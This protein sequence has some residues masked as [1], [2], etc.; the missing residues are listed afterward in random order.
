MHLIKR[1][2]GKEV[3]VWACP[4]VIDKASGRKFGKSEGN[5]IWLDPAR[6]SV[7]DYYQFWINA[8]DESVESLLKI[9]TEIPLDEVAEIMKLH[10]RNPDQRGAQKALALAATEILHG[11]DNAVNVVHI[12]NVL[13]GDEN[14]AELSRDGLA[15]L[16][17][18][19]P[20]A[21]KGV[22]V[23]EALI[24]AGLAA[25]KGEAARLIKAGAVSLNGAK[26]GEDVKVSDLTLLKKGKN[27][28]VLIK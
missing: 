9:Y 5:A 12:T 20:T 1:L 10:L 3:D 16:G 4:L 22:S 2:E 24:G 23:V 7:F 13:F 15:L 25:S 28:F 26:I 14:I 18:T 27:S 6:T 11:R 19:I 21:K 17:Q 8:S